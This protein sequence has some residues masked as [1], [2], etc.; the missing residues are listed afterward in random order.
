MKIAKHW[1]F[2]NE[3]FIIVSNTSGDIIIFSMFFALFF[4]IFALI[5]ME[6]FGNI[7]KFDSNNLKDLA[8]GTSFRFNFDDFSNAFLTCFSLMTGESWTWVSMPYTRFNT[9]PGVI[10]IISVQCF[11]N[12]IL[13]NLFLAIFLQNFFSDP[14]KVKMDDEDKKNREFELMVKSRSK[15]VIKPVEKYHKQKTLLS[16]L[17][18]FRTLITL[19]RSKRDR[20]YKELESGVILEGI[21][22]DYFHHDNIIRIIIGTIIESSIFIFF[23]FAVIVA[24]SIILTYDTPFNDPNGSTAELIRDFN[25]CT[26]IF[27]IIEIILKSITYGLISNGPN[28]YF[29]N[30]WNLF[31]FILTIINFIDICLTS[32]QY[33]IRKVFMLC[34]VLRVL[35]ITTLNSG[36]RLCLQAIVNG[37]SQIIQVLAMGLMFFVIYAII[38]VH[39]FGG[40]LYYCEGPELSSLEKINTVYD[41][42]NYGAEWKLKDANFD[43]VLAALMLEFEMFCAKGFV[44]TVGPLSDAEEYDLQPKYKNHLYR[45]IFLSLFVVIGYL[46]IRAILTGI[47]TILN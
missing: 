5:G 10:Y 2:L 38:C 24:N 11:L 20:R 35:K 3:I 15:N 14:E 40:L 25:I 4:I 41:C 29:Q 18:V 23:S 1:P 46:F 21:S 37:Y 30:I 8:N 44:A 16:A 6:L 27:F 39:F 36:F 42:M 45:V 17:K 26:V 12:I 9:I 47:I 22:F 19:A 34:R 28:S 7:V 13:T 33:A 32:E 31:D 43:N